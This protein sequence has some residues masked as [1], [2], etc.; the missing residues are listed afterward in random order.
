MTKNPP[1]LIVDGKVL[2]DG[3]PSI[4]CHMLDYILSQ[5]KPK[6][7]T[8]LFRPLL[9]FER[10]PKNKLRTKD[11]SKDVIYKATGRNAQCTYLNYC[12]FCGE[13]LQANETL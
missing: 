4:C 5:E 7:R 9:T 12:P 2:R 8:G 1:P 3:V 11:Q 13:S 10:A 6:A